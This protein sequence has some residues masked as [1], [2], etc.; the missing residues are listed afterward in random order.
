MYRIKKHANKNQYLHVG[1]ELWVRNPGIAGVPF[2]DINNLLSAADYP[3]MLQNEQWS[4]RAKYPW[5]DTENI[6]ATK[7]VI[8]SDGFNFEKGHEQVAALPKDVLIFAVNGA[9]SKWTAKRTPNFYVLNNP[10]SEAQNYLPRTTTTKCIT[11][12]RSNS[13]F[14]KRYTG[15]KFRYCPANDPRYCGIDNKDCKYKI[16]DYRNPV[17]A[18]INLLYRFGVQKLAL[19]FCDDVFEDERPASVQSE[20]GKWYYPQHLTANKLIDGNLYWLGKNN[21]C[22]VVQHCAGPKLKAAT[23]IPLEELSRFF[24]GK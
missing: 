16:D 24:Q 1:D 9:L 21:G 6:I 3:L 13:E 10:Y 5:I 7:A 11:S 23:Y 12:T 8:V 15:A 2:H 17:C 19:M 18:S 4:L 20:D 14:L 22:K